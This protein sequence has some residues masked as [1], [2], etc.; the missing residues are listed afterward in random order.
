VAGTDGHPRLRLS[1]GFVREYDGVWTDRAGEPVF[2]DPGGPAGGPPAPGELA[3]LG[4]EEVLDVH[5][6]NAARCSENSRRLGALVSLL[7]ELRS[8]SATETPP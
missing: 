8:R 1:Y 7:R 6:E 2:R 5:A 4:L 3:G